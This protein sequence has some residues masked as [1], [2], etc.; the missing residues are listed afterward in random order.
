MPRRSVTSDGQLRCDG[1]KYE[2]RLPGRLSS[3]VAR[4]IRESPELRNRAQGG[5][6]NHVACDHIVPRNC[7]AEAPISPEGIPHDAP[8]FAPDFI[9]AHADV[10]ILSSE[11]D[12]RLRRAGWQSDIPASWWEASHDID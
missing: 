5:L 8:A 2:T 6:Q 3:A 9:I 4:V 12:L 10:A 11:V 1:A 7:V